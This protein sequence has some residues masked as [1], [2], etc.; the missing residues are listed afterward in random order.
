MDPIDINTHFE[1]DTEAQAAVPISPEAMATMVEIG[2]EINASLDLDHVLGRAAELIRRLIEYEIFAVMLLDER[3][4]QLAFRFAIG[5]RPEIVENMRISL[6][7]GVTGRA[8]AQGQPVLVRDV[9]QE[10]NYIN[11]LDSV[12]SELAVPL[13]F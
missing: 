8:A 1:I 4:G 10:P 12:R 6:G 5:H 3:T 9:S 7:Q 13:M 11:V 2:E